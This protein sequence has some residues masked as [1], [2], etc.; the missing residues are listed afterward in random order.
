MYV[1]Y[2]EAVSQ[3]ATKVGSYKYAKFFTVYVY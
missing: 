2:V 1:E 3:M